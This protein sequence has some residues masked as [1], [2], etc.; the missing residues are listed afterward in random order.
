MAG[1]LSY[2]SDRNDALRLFLIEVARRPFAYGKNDCL[3]WLAD[4]G[5]RLTGVDVGACWRGRCSTKLG[6]ARILRQNGGMVAVTGAAFEP[7]GWRRTETPKR[8]DIAIVHEAKEGLTG[9]ICLGNGM[10]AMARFEGRL[11]FKRAP[12]VAAWS[13]GV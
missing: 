2:P 10:F 7:E 12:V 9:A 11:L 4:W 13:W 1:L 8:G 5:I 6:A 3:L